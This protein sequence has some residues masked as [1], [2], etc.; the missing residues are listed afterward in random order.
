MKKIYTVIL[1][2]F[3][4]T[5]WSQ[6]IPM[7]VI[8]A[9]GGYFENTTAGLSISWTL[10]EVAYTTLTSTDYILTQGFQQGNLFTTSVEKPTNPLNDIAIYPNPAKEFVKVRVEIPNVAGKATFELY[11]I[12][13]RKLISKE[14][15]VEQSVPVELSLSEIRPGIYLLKVTLERDNLNRIVKFVKE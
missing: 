1:S 14:M 5:A 11:D 6:D 3:T 4:L 15:V 9:G 10:G 13:G 2:L 12:T 8:A 7:Q